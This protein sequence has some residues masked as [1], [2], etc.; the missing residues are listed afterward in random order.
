MSNDAEVELDNEVGTA[1]IVAKEERGKMKKERNQEQEK[2]EILEVESKIFEK[3][4][5]ERATEAIATKRMPKRRKR[6]AKGRKRRV[7]N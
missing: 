4:M 1:Q 7:Q 3:I 6:K 5:R 2:N